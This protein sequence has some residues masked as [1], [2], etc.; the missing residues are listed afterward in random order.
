MTDGL[1]AEMGASLESYEAQLTR[2]LGPVVGGHQL[3]QALGYR[4][5]A[6]FRKPCS[7]AP[8]P[9]K[10]SRWQA[11][12]AALRPRPTLQLGSGAS[13]IARFNASFR[14]CTQANGN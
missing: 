9:S 6:A 1:F 11:V 13:A 12:A 10:P 4:T 5:P 8:C 14:P 7:A 2:T 3:V